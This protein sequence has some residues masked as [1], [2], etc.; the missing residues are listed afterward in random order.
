MTQH[1]LLPNFPPIITIS[2]PPS[3]SL[4]PSLSLEFLPFPLWC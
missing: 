2:L 4:L 3:L 1:I